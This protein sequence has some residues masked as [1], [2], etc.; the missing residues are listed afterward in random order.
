MDVLE[1]PS[2]NDGIME[3]EGTQESGWRLIVSLIIIAMMMRF[4]MNIH[5]AHAH[6]SRFT[7]ITSDASNRKTVH[8]RT[9]GW[10]RTLDDDYDL[11]ACAGWHR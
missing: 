3:A 11:R 4:V 6:G 5:D 7:R 8:V 1:R 9:L 2:R 10:L